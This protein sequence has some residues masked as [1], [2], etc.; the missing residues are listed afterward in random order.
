MKS[1]RKYAGLMV[2]TKELGKV[3]FATLSKTGG[4]IDAYDAFMMAK[5]MK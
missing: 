2:K 5:D 3:D 4:V 1:S